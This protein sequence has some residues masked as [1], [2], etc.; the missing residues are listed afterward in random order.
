MH[1]S[2]W[3]SPEGIPT[4]TPLDIYRNL[5]FDLKKHPKHFLSKKLLVFPFCRALQ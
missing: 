3:D 2:M 4:N 5:A 1:L